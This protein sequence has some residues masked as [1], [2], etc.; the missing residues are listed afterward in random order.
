VAVSP[1]PPAGFRGAFHT[2][3]RACAL[4]SEGA[5]PLRIVPA[6][7]A[8]PHGRDDLVALVRHAAAEGSTLV[9]RGAGTGMPGHNVGPGVVVDLHAFERPARVALTGI[10]NVGAALTCGVVNKIA[11]HFGMRFPPDPSSAAYC[12][13]GGMVAT[14][15]AGA[16]SLRSGSVRAWVRGVEFV[17]ADWRMHQIRF[18][19]DSLD[20]AHRA[21]LE[22]TDQMDSPP[23]VDRDARFVV[24]FAEAPEGRYPFVAEGNEAPTLGVVVV[25]PKR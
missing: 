12:T 21:F 2:D 7:V 15:A 1:T 20:A 23:L 9:P 11:G 8:L 4:Y 13:V 18:V 24:S 22:G 25:L 3:A 5:G 6:A 19:A 14:N 10:A 16:R 17:T